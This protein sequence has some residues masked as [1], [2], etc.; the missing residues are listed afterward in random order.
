[1][2]KFIEAK[3]A[4]Y[5]GGPGQGSGGRMRLVQM[6]EAIGLQNGACVCARACARVC[7]LGDS[8]WARRIRENVDVLTPNK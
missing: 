1:M 8:Q 7:M 6:Q 2:L 4:E 3:Q 5:D